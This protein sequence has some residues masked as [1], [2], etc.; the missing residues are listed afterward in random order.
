MM[1]QWKPLAASVALAAVLAASASAKPVTYTLRTVADGRIGAR[2]FN[3]ATLT[4]TFTGD[5]RN[6]MQEYVSGQPVYYNRKGRATVKVE[7][8]GEVTVAH[9]AAGEIYVQYNT[10]TGV[11]GFGSS[12]SPSYPVALDCNNDSYYGG[13][14]CTK[15]DW[16]T[17]YEVG[18]ADALVDIA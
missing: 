4:F 2:N 6:V 3:Q 8:D 1:S 11:V 7:Q 17:G 12:I 14:G 5:T 18:T 9:F 13:P 16:D 10:A 15:G